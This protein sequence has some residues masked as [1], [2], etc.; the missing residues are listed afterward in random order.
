MNPLQVTPERLQ[1]GFHEVGLQRG[2]L[3]YVASSLAALGLMANPVGE[4]LA[5]LRA[6]VGPEGTLV[7]PAFNFDFC[8]GVPFDRERSP[9]RTGVL[10]E[11]FRQLPGTRRT[12]APPFHS[13]TAAGPLAAELAATEALTSFGPDSVF[14]RLHDLG[15]KQLLLGCGFH[16]GAAHVHWLEEMVQVPY[17]HWKRFEGDVV[18][19]GQTRRRSFF[20]YARSE[21]PKVSV[22]ATELGLAF[23]ATPAVRSATVGLCRLQAFRLTD[24]AEFARPRFTENPLLLLA[25]DQRPAFAA[26]RSPVRR[27]DHLGIVSRYA[28]RIR[29]FFG[30]IGC[31]LEAE[32]IV[33]ELGVNCEYHAGL[34]VTIELVDPVTPDSR[35]RHHVERNP[36][37]PLHH[38]ALEVDDLD[39]ALPYFKARG[40]EPLDGRRHLGPRPYQRVLFLSPVQT[41]GLLIE[42]VANDGRKARAYGGNL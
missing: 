28:D 21:R 22:D 3:V 2:D 36:G 17:R 7:M 41:G 42:L 34:D 29:D 35:V 9:A 16:E 31:Q 19:D 8:A 5:A 38:V 15:A 12:W 11:A 25:A 27:I 23:A 30:A 20:M 39:D 33:P 40:Y 6:A 32:G 4:T 26:T 10:S 1:A 18:C 24:F 13:V 37:C 14:Q